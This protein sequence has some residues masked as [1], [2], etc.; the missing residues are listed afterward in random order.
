MHFLKK[1]C[2]AN[3]QKYGDYQMRAFST[4]AIRM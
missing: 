4:I 1:R 2:R 3:R